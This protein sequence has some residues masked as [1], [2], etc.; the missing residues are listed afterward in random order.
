MK[1]LKSGLSFYDKSKDGSTVIQD[2]M[3]AFQRE[4]YLHEHA[5]QDLINHL[6]DFCQ[7]NQVPFT[8]LSETY[9]KKVYEEEADQYLKWGWGGS[10]YI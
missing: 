4:A 2:K 7:K 3:H 5:Y 1:T 8:R 10:K 9:L 6:S